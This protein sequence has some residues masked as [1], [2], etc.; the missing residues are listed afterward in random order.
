MP[1]RKAL[2]EA[3]YRLCLFVLPAALAF[4]YVVS[5]LPIISLDAWL[6]I[7]REGMVLYLFAP[8]GTVVVIPLMMLRL[9]SLAAAPHEFALLLLSVVFVDVFVALWVAWNWDL[10][11]R[12]PRLGPL[13]R[14]VEAGCQRVIAQ[15]RWRGRVTIAAL[16][17]Y[18]ALPFPLTGAVFSSVLGRTLGIDRT[19]VFLAVVVGSAAGTVPMGV[20]GFFAA[21]AVLN[22]F[23]SPTAQ[24][25]GAAAGILITVAFVALVA[26]LYLRGKRAENRG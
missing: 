18:V 17:G 8:V 22:T 1:Q 24:A 9:H 2:P 15:K 21:E 20:A 6:V 14:R 19:R 4:V 10:V 11:E 3:V 16:A 26:V 12:V 5:L 23:Q 13:L 25:V 7:V